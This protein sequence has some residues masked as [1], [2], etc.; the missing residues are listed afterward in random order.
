MEHY[1]L[2]KNWIQVNWKC[3]MMMIEM[4]ITENDLV[5]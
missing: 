4:A 2:E 5:S 3:T 1:F